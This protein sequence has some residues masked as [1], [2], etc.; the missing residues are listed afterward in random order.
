MLCI[1]EKNP[2]I[3]IL[4]IIGKYFFPFFFFLFN[5]WLLFGL[6]ECLIPLAQAKWSKL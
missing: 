5:L 4:Q 1:R 2:Q 3:M 6:A